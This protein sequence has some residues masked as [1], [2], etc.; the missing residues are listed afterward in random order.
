MKVW[1][2][3]D[4]VAQRTKGD[5][6]LVMFMFKPP[7][8]KCA[9]RR[10]IGQVSQTADTQIYLGVGGLSRFPIHRRLPHVRLVNAGFSAC[11]C[12]LLVDHIGEDAVHRR[13]HHLQR[14]RQALFP[15]VNCVSRTTNLRTD[16]ARDTVAF[17]LSTYC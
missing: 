14:R 2:D 12:K 3:C 13:A 15:C 8:L 5:G 6:G 17:A 9:E 11:R 10:Q 7:T 16:S 4:S 1:A